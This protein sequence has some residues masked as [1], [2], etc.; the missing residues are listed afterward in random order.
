MFERVSR[1]ARFDT[2]LVLTEKQ[3]R[4]VHRYRPARVRVIF[5]LPPRLRYLF[6]GK[7][8]YVE[9]FN[10]T[11]HKPLHP[12]G[13]FT[14]TRSILDGFRVCAVIPLSD[15]RMTCHLAP[16]YNLFHPE[17]PLTIHS[18]VLQLCE[19]FFL[20]IF[21]TYFCYELFRHWSQEGSDA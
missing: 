14:T 3:G 7:L 13:L 8:A 10:A 20:N 11:S 19:K 1:P 4:G 6:E 16:R 9:M 2:V 21:A 12:T 15:I 5:E 17:T 18:D